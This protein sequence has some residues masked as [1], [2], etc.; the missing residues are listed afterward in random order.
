MVWQNQTGRHPYFANEENKNWR[1]Y[2]NLQFEADLHK[3]KAE[4]FQRVNEYLLDRENLR[5]GHVDPKTD[6]WVDTE[7]QFSGNPSGWFKGKK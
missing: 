4:R 2:D 5:D 3:D 6:E 7:G 1:A